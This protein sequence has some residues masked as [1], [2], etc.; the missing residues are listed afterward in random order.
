MRVYKLLFMLTIFAAFFFAGSPSETQVSAQQQ[1]PTTGK[2]KGAKQ[3][4]AIPKNWVYVYEKI[5]GYGFY[6]PVGTSVETSTEDGVDVLILQTPGNN[7][8][9]V[10]VLAYKD[11]TKTK[12]DLLDDALEF[13]TA[14][15]QTVTT[16]PLRGESE[17]YALADATTVLEDGTRG[18]VRVLVG[19]DVTD[20]YIMILG[21][22]AKSFA[23]NEPVIDLIWG[24][25][26]MWS[27]R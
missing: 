17:N 4:T 1:R 24:S 2:A 25:F 7:P 19:T 15:G 14:L 21:S 11:K 3:G 22:D 9:D 20:N 10:F 16:E 5:K 27:G 6:V 23:A 12:E 18:K 13:L 8:V 26:E